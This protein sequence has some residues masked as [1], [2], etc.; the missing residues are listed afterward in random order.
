L[1]AEI[2]GMESLAVR[3]DGNLP[4][5]IKDALCTGDFVPLYEP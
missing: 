3:V 4:R 2:A 1:P 5:T